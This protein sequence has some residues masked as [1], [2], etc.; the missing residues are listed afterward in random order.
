MTRPY[1]PEELLELIIPHLDKRKMR[2]RAT[3][4]GKHV[5]ARCPFHDDDEPSLSLTA[6][7]DKLLTHCFVCGNVYDRLLELAGIKSATARPIAPRRN[8]QQPATAQAQPLTLAALADAKRLDAEKLRAWGLT[9]LPDGG[10]EIPYRDTNGNTV[11]IRYRLA[12]EGD[13]RFK[14]R[15]DDTPC[16]YG[17]WRLYDWEFGSD[18]YLCE[19]ETDALTLWH[20]GLPA[21][22][23][24]GAT[25]WKPEWWRN[26]WEFGRIVIIPDADKAG[27]QMTERLVATC[28]D[29]LRERVQVLRLP[30]GIKDA[31][32]L[33]QQVDADPE[34]FR[35]ALAGCNIRAIVQFL[36]GLHDCTIARNDSEDDLPLLAPLSELL[37]SD[38]EHELEYVPLLGVDGLIAR[39]TITL[40]GAHPKAGKTTLLIHA[41]RA[42]VQQNRRVVYLSEDSRPVWRERVKRFPELGALILNAIPRAH[43][44]NWARAV[45]ELEPDIVIVDTIRRFMP[46]KDEND[47]A[48]VSLALAPFVDLQQELP[49]TAIVL[50]HHTKKSLSSEGEITDIAGSHAFTAEVD[51]ILLLAPVREHKRQRI[52]TP[53]AGRLWTLSPEPLVL[54]LSEDASEYRVVGTAEEVLPETHTQST[55]GKILDALR[56]LGLATVDEV[57]DYL[58]AQGE[59]VSK[60]TIHHHLTQLHA[61]GAVNREGR[62]T[63]AEPYTYSCNRAIV[64]PLNTLHDCTNCDLHETARMEPPAVFQNRTPYTWDLIDDFLQRA[65]NPEDPFHLEPAELEAVRVM[66]AYAEARSFPSLVVDGYTIRGDMAGWLTAAQQL[67]GTP[68]VLTATRLLHAL[69]A[70]GTPHAPTHNTLLR[71]GDAS[72]TPSQLSLEEV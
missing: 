32:E 40:L 18:L 16:L 72:R 62:G 33:W 25:A 49:R 36:K 4:D 47:S 70:S 15:K 50:V 67:A 44:E 66:L 26:L 54:E 41:C 65:S 12:L 2:V 22:G 39:G 29:H 11:A 20:A 42:W 17:L 71:N 9:D 37:S 6:R 55:K 1:T 31:N 63:R 69:D 34:R 58:R 52:L 5:M 46:A 60:R 64:Q 13:A 30:D 14:W 68:A 57:S 28:P 48:S 59:Q 51:A 10:I 56:V 61:E 19:G 21:L 53:I 23:I 43:P 24:P 38:A 35:E 7:K 8:R 27:E 45:R 3:K